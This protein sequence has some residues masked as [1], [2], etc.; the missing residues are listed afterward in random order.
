MVILF[1]ILDEF[2]YYFKKERISQIRCFF[3]LVFVSC[4]SQFR[5]SCPCQCQASFGKGLKVNTECHTDIGA[6]LMGLK[7]KEEIWNPVLRKY[8]YCFIFRM[9][10]WKGNLVF[11]RQKKDIAAEFYNHVS[12]LV[13]IAFRESWTERGHNGK[14][15]SSLISE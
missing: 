1:G 5:C 15:A 14:S 3:F 8:I 11:S 13:I 2:R 4:H 10:I 12:F 9:T 7:I 6:Q